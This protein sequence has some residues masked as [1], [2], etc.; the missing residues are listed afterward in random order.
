MSTRRRYDT[1]SKPQLK[2]AAGKSL[3]LE[4][5]G[6]ITEPRRRTFC[7]KACEDNFRLKTSPNHVRQMV[8][9]RDNGICAK[10]RVDTMAAKRA[11]GVPDVW[12]RARGTGDLWQADHI[13]PVIEGG[14]ECG[15]ENFRTLCSACHKEETA[16]LA[17]RR[18]VAR[19]GPPTQFSKDRIATSSRQT[20]LFEADAT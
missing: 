13:V 7:G 2:D 5:D 11:S 20:S 3:C 14:G 19:R 8:F 1:Y 18:A 15:L 6:P 17:K 16:M 4:C 10:C 12:L 9:R